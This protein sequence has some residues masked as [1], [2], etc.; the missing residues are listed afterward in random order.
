VGDLINSANSSLKRVKV[1]YQ[2]P[3]K[4]H[5]AVVVAIAA[6]TGVA[7]SFG[8]EQVYPAAFLACAITYLAQKRMP[9]RVNMPNPGVI[10]LMKNLLNF[11]FFL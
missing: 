1:G 10:Q 9:Y 11:G 2:F 3:I 6:A 8:I 7:Y 5:S 4:D